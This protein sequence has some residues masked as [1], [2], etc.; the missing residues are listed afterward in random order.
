MQHSIFALEISAPFQPGS[1]LHVGLCELVRNHP[2]AASLQEKWQIYRHATDLLLQWLPTF[3][4][5]CWDF[6]DDD[7]RA[8]ADFMMWCNGMFTE[9]GS[10]KQPSGHPD[11]YRADPR[12]L[13]FTIALLLVQG[14]PTERLLAQ[15]CNIPEQH[16]W[17]RDV[18]H[19]LIEGL[20]YVNFAS[21][22]GDVMYLIPRDGDW[23]LTAQDLGHEKFKYLRQ[24]A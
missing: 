2:I 18:F 15:R 1:P 22:K 19:H 14:T 17:R 24:I 5:G 13:T 23:G 20:P 8:Q 11:P 21:V 12:Y 3:E 4:R 10:R 7:Q 16:L 9:E 6:F